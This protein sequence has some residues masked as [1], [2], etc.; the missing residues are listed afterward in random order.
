[1]PSIP[2][3]RYTLSQLVCAYHAGKTQYSTALKI[4]NQVASSFLYIT[5]IL[6]FTKH[7]NHKK[8]WQKLS[9]QSKNRSTDLLPTDSHRVFLSPGSEDEGSDYIN[10]SWLT[11]DVVDNYEDDG[12]NELVRFPNQRSKIY[13]PFV[14]IEYGVEV[15][16]ELYKTVEKLN[17]PH[18]GCYHSW[19]RVW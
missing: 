6:I 9:L 1:M 19:Q 14:L 5:N 16:M 11:G 2:P 4:C 10:A 13:I 7:K 8:V 17:T 15:K 12:D 18:D 3:S